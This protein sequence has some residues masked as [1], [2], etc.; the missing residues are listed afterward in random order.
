MLKRLRTSAA[1]IAL[2]GILNANVQIAYATLAASLPPNSYFPSSSDI[3]SRWR[4]GEANGV[5]EDTA[6]NND[7]SDNNTVL[8]AAAQFGANGAD[9]ELDTA[10]SLSIADGSQTGLEM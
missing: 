1:I 7:L 2:V 6:G 10:E 3:V 4:L 8:A 5:R 9:F